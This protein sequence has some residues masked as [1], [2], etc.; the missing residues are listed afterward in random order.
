M[1]NHKAYVA[2]WLEALN[3]DSRFIFRA[4][5]AASKAAD[6][7]FRS[8]R[9]SSPSQSLGSSLLRLVVWSWHGAVARSH[10]PVR[11]FMDR[12]DQRNQQSTTEI[13]TMTTTLGELDLE[14]AAKEAAGNWRE[15]DCFSWDRS[16]EIE[17]ADQFCLVYTH[18]RDSG[19]LDQ[20]NAEAIHEAMEPFLDRDLVM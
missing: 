7:S 14:S 2:N 6:F 17:D 18:N 9:S 3:K 12:H 8:L 11:I 20:S 19:L 1:S 13:M 10:R 16:N 15:F 5:S 4:A